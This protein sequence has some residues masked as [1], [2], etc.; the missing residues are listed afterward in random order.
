MVKDPKEVEEV[1]QWIKEMEQRGNKE[2]LS[3][4][5]I[6]TLINEI[7]TNNYPHVWGM[8]YSLDSSDQNVI[9]HWLVI[10]QP[11]PAATITS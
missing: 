6:Q 9:E 10:Q 7:N 1:K 5:I 11:L 4:L 8:Q 3:K 2:M